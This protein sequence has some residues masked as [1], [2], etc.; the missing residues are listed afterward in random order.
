MKTAFTILLLVLMTGCEI[1]P[2]QTP[3][4][5]KQNSFTTNSDAY[6]TVL[7]SNIAEA[8]ETGNPFYTVTNSGEPQC[9]GNYYQTYLP[10]GPGFL[11][12]TNGNGANFAMLQI[13]G[14]GWG[15]LFDL[16][17][18]LNTGIINAYYVNTNGLAGQFQINKPGY[19]D[20]PGAPPAPFSILKYTGQQ[21]NIN[22][23]ELAAA[24][25]LTVRNYT[26]YADTNGA[27]AYFY[28]SLPPP[29]NPSL[30]TQAQLSSATNQSAA[31]MQSYA[32]SASSQTANQ[33][34]SNNQSHY[35]SSAGINATAF[36]A[37]VVNSL[38]A[39]TGVTLSSNKTSAGI[40]CSV[41]LTGTNVVYIT[42]INA[43]ALSG[44]GAFTTN[45][46]TWSG[47][48][49]P[50][51]DWTNAAGY[52]RGIISTSTAAATLQ[53]KG[54]YLTG[55][56]NLNYSKFTNA[57]AIPSTNGF[58]TAAIVA[59]LASVAYVQ[60]LNFLT[61]NL[62]S[63]YAPTSLV[64]SSL[65]GYPTNLSSTTNALQSQINTNS[66]NILLRWG[67]NHAFVAA[68]NVNS[69]MTATFT[70]NGSGVITASLG[71]TTNLYTSSYQPASQNLTNWASIPTNTILLTT[72]L[73]TSI[74][75]GNNVLITFTTNSAGVHAT[76]NAYYAYN[77]PVQILNTST[78]SNNGYPF[79]SD[80]TTT[81]SWDK[82]LPATPTS[83]K[84]FHNGNLVSTSGL[85]V[86]YSATGWQILDPSNSVL[87]SSYSI[88]VVGVCK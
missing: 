7:V 74:V 16:N 47:T 8:I 9:A 11:A 51:N 37:A 63:Y 25:A 2:A 86:T 30:A 71:S 19:S 29:S 44:W 88:N 24:G 79:G 67:T 68:I 31:A 69:N 14:T 52:F 85:T 72:N 15:Y 38:S 43:V 60:E 33:V 17:A 57:P 62:L 41:S 54:S 13:N 28:T 82:P 18:F 70:T 35:I 5:I 84:I 53:P 10:L 6:C 55:T 73:V 32:N 77:A 1:C 21:G 65:S 36:K 12:Y 3:I 78:H 87:G 45:P 59:P 49:A 42:N 39:G 4:G 23:S 58:V 76:V 50:T 27:A 75:Q 56:S 34:Y 61:T 64:I 83:F 40:S 66:T 20:Y 22:Q 46:I 26:A 48:I 81:K 80:N